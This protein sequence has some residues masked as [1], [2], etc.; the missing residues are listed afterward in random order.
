MRWCLLLTAKVHIC[1][2][3]NSSMSA[4]TCACGMRWKSAWTDLSETLC[5]ALIALLPQFQV[6]CMLLHQGHCATIIVLGSV[7]HSHPCSL[8]QLVSRST[9]VVLC[10]QTHPGAQAD[11]LQWPTALQLLFGEL[12]KMCCACRH[13]LK[14]RQM[15]RSK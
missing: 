7:S 12:S 10:R 3:L 1:Q 4:G 11:V 5:P 2:S 8:Q 13:T 14:H 15:W 6:E 9:K